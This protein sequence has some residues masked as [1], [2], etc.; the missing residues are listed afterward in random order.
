MKEK[1]FYQERLKGMIYGRKEDALG[2]WIKSDRFNIIKKNT[3]THTSVN[4]LHVPFSFL[5]YKATRFVRQVF[6]WVTPALLNTVSTKPMLQLSRLFTPIK[7]IYDGLFRGV[8]S[9][10]K[11]FGSFI[12]IFGLNKLLWRYSDPAGSER[13]VLPFVSKLRWNNGNRSQRVIW[14][15]IWPVCPDCVTMRPATWS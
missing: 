3:N 11:P 2:K 9:V 4:G 7:P 12:T 15:G 10:A 13:R 14:T 5:H 8:K 1:T 6:I